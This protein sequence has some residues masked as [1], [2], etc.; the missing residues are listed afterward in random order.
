MV[1]KFKK[2]PLDRDFGFVASKEDVSFIKDQVFALDLNKNKKIKIIEEPRVDV[3]AVAVA[4][5]NTILETIGREEATICSNAF[6][7]GIM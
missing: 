1:R 4:I 6:I 5:L 7:R 3:F 2:Y